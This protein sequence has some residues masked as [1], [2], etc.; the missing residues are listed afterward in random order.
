MNLNQTFIT[1]KDKRGI[2]LKTP[3]GGSAISKM[4]NGFQE[5]FISD[6][7]VLAE[8]LMNDYKTISLHGQYKKKKHEPITKFDDIQA[9]EMKIEQKEW[10]IK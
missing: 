3:R 8:K 4:H 6:G 2:S 7:A 5:S 10:N 9:T 1:S